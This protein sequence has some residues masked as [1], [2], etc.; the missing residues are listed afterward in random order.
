MACNGSRRLEPLSARKSHARSRPSGRWV[1]SIGGNALLTSPGEPSS[2]PDQEGAE[3]QRLPGQREVP[4]V[5]DLRPFEGGAEDLDLRVI[6]DRLGPARLAPPE[7]QEQRN[8]A[9]ISSG[10]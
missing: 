3:P 1:W 9:T 8:C 2:P 10:L 7:Q 5:I 6:E 4:F